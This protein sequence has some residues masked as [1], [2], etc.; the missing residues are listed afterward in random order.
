M[1][2]D[3]E[4]EPEAIYRTARLYALAIE[5]MVIGGH[6]LDLF[7]PNILYEAGA[8]L[9]LSR[10]SL[11]PLHHELDLAEPGVL[12]NFA[13][14]SPMHYNGWWFMGLP[15]RLIGRH[16]LPMPCFIRGDD[17]EFGLRLHEAGV[18]IVSTPGIGIWHEPFYAKLG[19]WHLYYE[20]RN[21]LVLVSRHRQDPA[22]ALMRTTL[23]WII[24]DLLTFRYQRAALLL[25]AANDFIDGPEIFSRNPQDVHRS[26]NAIRT[27]FPPL[28][29][30]RFKVL[31]QPDPPE[32]PRSR[33]SL[34]LGV[35]AA[36][37]TEWHRRDGNRTIRIHPR[38]HLWFRVRGADLVAVD[39][40]WEQDLPT[41][42]RSRATFRA[43]AQQSFHLWLRMR[44]EMPLA[45]TRW[46]EAHPIF[47]GEHF[48]R[49]YLVM[50]PARATGEAEA[51]PRDRPRD[52]GA[53]LLAA[54]DD[55]ELHR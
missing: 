10:L 11:E 13:D 55:I 34:F 20:F 1:D 38:D 9:N 14:A 24:A 43:L 36:L 50:A 2:D 32:G 6:M 44:R 26:L 53:E 46:K 27:L 23:R 40:S 4:I 37:L 19:S 41:Y 16:G 30:A 17:V 22:P 52:A 7:R 39:E 54:P 28:R 42:R 12:S 5:D 49:R 51:L 48:W 35:A 45:A 25:R 31:E 8:R 33:F 29:T 15:L 21:M 3:V 47:T 18:P